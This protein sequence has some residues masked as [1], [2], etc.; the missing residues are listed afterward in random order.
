MLF[1]SLTFVIFFAVVLAVHHLPINWWFKKLNLLLASYIFYAAWNPPFVLLLWL[2]TVVDYVAAAQISKSDKLAARRG[3]LVLSMTTNL[4]IP[5]Q[6]DHPLFDK[7]VR[8][9]IKKARA[10]NIGAGIHFW[11]SV[12]QEIEWAKAGLNLLFHHHQ[13]W[14]TL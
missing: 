6:Y 1:N 4:G 14:Y 7:T 3:W 9:I 8:E 5:Q 2:S 10:K 13:F 12:D 11:P